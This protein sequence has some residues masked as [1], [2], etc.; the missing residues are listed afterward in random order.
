MR[1]GSYNFGSVTIDGVT[2]HTDVVIDRGEVRKRQKSASKRLRE[3]YGHTPLS[4]EED[5]PWECRQLVVGT[6]Q[7]GGLPIAD[8]LKQEAKRRHV[9]L[10]L[11]RTGEAVKTLKSKPSG[12]NAVLHLTC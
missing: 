10:V 8:E 5:I 4:V 12:T 11:L 2:Y 6:G 3:E 9:K 7:M 1:F